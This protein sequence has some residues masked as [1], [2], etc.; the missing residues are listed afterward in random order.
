MTVCEMAHLLLADSNRY[1]VM[2]DCFPNS[3][4]FESLVSYLENLRMKMAMDV[5]IYFTSYR[6]AGSR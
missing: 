2:V 1:N 3:D 5:D 6:V 4:P